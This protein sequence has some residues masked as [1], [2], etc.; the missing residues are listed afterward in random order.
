MAMHAI[1]FFACRGVITADKA[2]SCAALMFRGPRCCALLCEA[3]G[4]EGCLQLPSSHLKSSN[5]NLLQHASSDCMNGVYIESS[6]YHL[7]AIDKCIC[8]S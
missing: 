5:P 8:E 3:Q 1:P 6:L 7:A 4:L 2:V